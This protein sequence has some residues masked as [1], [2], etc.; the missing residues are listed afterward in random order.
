MSEGLADRIHAHTLFFQEIVDLIPAQYLKPAELGLDPEEGGKREKKVSSKQEKDASLSLSELR[1]RLHAK[2]EEA[3]QRRGA[4]PDAYAGLRNSG[5]ASKKR[6]ASDSSA[7][8]SSG[9][10]DGDGEDEAPAPKG[11]KGPKG[12]KAP[13]QKGEKKEKKEKKG[14]D[15]KPQATQ[16]KHPRDRSPAP[17]QG[18][19][20]KK[21][22]MEKKPKEKDGED[23]AFSEIRVRKDKT[24]GPVD[25]AV[26]KM[27]KKTLLK[28]AEKEKQRIEK[29]KGTEAGR[30]EAAGIA[31]DR[32]A[33]LAAGIKL[34]DDPTLLKKA[35][36]R[37]EQKK[38]KS[39]KEW[40]Q[41]L[42]QQDKSRT[43]RATTRE[44]NIQQRH[45]AKVAAAKGEEPPAA[46]GKAKGGRR[47]GRGAGRGGGAAGAAGDK[48]PMKNAR[49]QG[50]PAGGKKGG[51]GPKG[52]KAFVDR[53]RGVI[54]RKPPKPLLQVAELSR[55]RASDP[56][57]RFS[58]GLFKKRKTSP[59]SESNASQSP[60]PDFGTPSQRQGAS[61]QLDSLKMALQPQQVEILVWLLTLSNQG[62]SGILAEETPGEGLVPT[63]GLLASLK[64]RWG[65]QVGPHLVVAPLRTAP[66]WKAELVKRCPTLKVA[67]LTGTAEARTC[68]LAEILGAPTGA[69][70]PYDICVTT[71][72]VCLRE[73][74]SLQ[75]PAWG[76]LVLDQGSRALALTSPLS[77]ALRSLQ[78]RQR[79]ILAASPLPTDLLHLCALAGL[80]DPGLLPPPLAMEALLGPLFT[81]DTAAPR[82]AT[83]IA[84]ALRPFVMPPRTGLG[85][86]TGGGGAGAAMREVILW[87][88]MTRAQRTRYSGLLRTLRPGGPPVQQLDLLMQ[89]RKCCAHPFLFVG[90]E[91]TRNN[92]DE[93]LAAASGKLA[94]LDS[95]LT[96][97]RGTRPGVRVAIV[98]ALSR[99]LDILQDWLTSRG[100]AHGRIDGMA[101]MEARRA[102]LEQFASPQSDQTT[103]LLSSRGAADLPGPLPAGALIFYDSD[104]NPQVDQAFISRCVGQE[105]CPGVTIYR[106]LTKVSQEQ[107][108]SP[109][110]YHPPVADITT[111][112]GYHHQ[113]WISPP[114]VDISPPVGSPAW[115]EGARGA[116]GTV[117]EPLAERARLQM[118]ANRQAAKTGQLP[119]PPTGPPLASHS[120]VMSASI[121]RGT[122]DEGTLGDMRGAALKPADLI[123]LI[124]YGSEALLGAE[125]PEAAP[126]G[127][128]SVMPSPNQSIEATLERAAAHTDEWIARMEA[129]Y[130]AQS[131]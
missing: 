101:G 84:E 19:G 5:P 22:R 93:A 83:R 105:G 107:W 54:D 26:P 106:L 131:H 34:K 129:Q 109:P 100:W 73:S 128:D 49:Q 91:P 82:A 77:E 74:L 88:E 35:L 10:E 37:D 76:C 7:D 1:E 58:E 12:K 80:L 87:A 6:P 45:Q 3:R 81:N 36:K 46:P 63:M 103:L 4:K 117:E 24:R 41:R 15:K 67:L 47:G 121:P 90:A 115:L 125:S 40:A 75:Q 42:K 110:G 116:R 127:G 28:K 16:K 31:W 68:L 111:S 71:Y 50:P 8:E 62:V 70:P 123:G 32:A 39:A 92:P 119:Q 99:M 23:L 108:I 53:L 11:P 69:P 114:A 98:S 21:P 61:T 56:K 51:K 96:H 59:H 48:R 65:P 66:I 104:G 25:G 113:R 102:A 14:A 78:A 9:A 72:E 33:Q 27:S 18:K 97:L 17:A 13:Q 20:A 64:A 124:N 52:P 112:G 126:S 30:R 89:L 95:L 118:I 43:D 94:L 38:R 85:A 57:A 44:A 130:A 86:G 60:P 2:I 122:F 55:V 79:V 120:R 29:L